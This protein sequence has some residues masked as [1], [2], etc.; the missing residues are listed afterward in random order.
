[1]VTV[2]AP[3]TLNDRLSK[4]ASEEAEELGY[5]HVCHY[6]AWESTQPPRGQH[7]S[8]T[9]IDIVSGS[10]VRPPPATKIGVMKA[11]VNSED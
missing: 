7:S 1:M 4:R 9:L 3:Q 10:D 6:L 5:D 8:T 11:G 2:A